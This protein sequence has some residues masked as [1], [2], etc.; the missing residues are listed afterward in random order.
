MAGK[1]EMIRQVDRDE[2]STVVERVRITAQVTKAAM[3]PS[4]HE[5]EI[6]TLSMS[7]RKGSLFRSADEWSNVDQ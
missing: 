3:K 2:E 4:S 7:P 6:R 1:G 5:S